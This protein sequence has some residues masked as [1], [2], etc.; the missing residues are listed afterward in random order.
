MTIRFVVN[1]IVPT[2]VAFAAGYFVV[3]GAIS[4][5]T[6]QVLQS[7]PPAVYVM[8]TGGGTAAVVLLYF[9]AQSIEKAFRR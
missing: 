1:Q 9:L 8:A 2:V 5:L 4:L 3:Y 6:P 7:A